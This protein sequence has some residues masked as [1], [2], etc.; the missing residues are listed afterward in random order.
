[1]TVVEL[2][3]KKRDGGELEADEIH[4]LIDAY[5]VDEVPDYQMAALLMASEPT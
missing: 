2:I 3:E 1:M 5:T 4:W